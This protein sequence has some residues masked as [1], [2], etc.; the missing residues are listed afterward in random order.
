[1]SVVIKG[2]ARLASNELTLFGTGACVGD[3][4]TVLLGPMW[5]AA[6]FIFHL[7]KMSVKPAAA[8]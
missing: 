6:S 5:A 2:T 8:Q 1:M 4:I 3:M 7:N